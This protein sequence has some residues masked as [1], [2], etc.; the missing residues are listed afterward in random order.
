MMKDQQQTLALVYMQ[1]D[2]QV[3]KNNNAEYI[4]APFAMTFLVGI[5][6]VV[7]DSLPI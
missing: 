6:H 7:L 4:H 1:H 5:I 3:L 2:N